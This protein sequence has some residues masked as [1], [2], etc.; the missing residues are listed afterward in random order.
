MSAVRSTYA[1]WG[2]VIRDLPV[3]AKPGRRFA[4]RYW[5]FG[6]YPLEP[7]PQLAGHVICVFETRKIARAAATVAQ[8]RSGTYWLDVVRVDV[9]VKERPH[10]TPGKRG[11]KGKG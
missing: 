7:E 10:R 3:M 1:G 9:T 2:V 4:G 11:G 8:D 5:C 6:H